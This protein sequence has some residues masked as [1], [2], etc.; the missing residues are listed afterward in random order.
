MGVPPP[1]G[2]NII[3]PK[4]AHHRLITM[5]LSEF[6][7]FLHR[8]LQIMNFKHVYLFL[9]LS[10]TFYWEIYSNMNN[11]HAQD[12]SCPR[13][14]FAFCSHGEKLS[15]Q[16]QLPGVVQWVTHLSKL[17]RGKDKFMWTVTDVRPCSEA[18]LA[19]GSESCPKAMS[20]PRACEQALKGCSLQVDANSWKMKENVISHREILTS[21]LTFIQGV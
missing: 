20:C 12:Y 17:L 13:A 3:A 4:Q 6:V 5:N 10:G 19:P 8:L 9:V 11:E 15:C 2:N 7:S 18:K 21:K 1:G 16:G 14:T